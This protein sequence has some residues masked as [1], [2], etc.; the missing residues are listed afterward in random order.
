[1][2]ECVVGWLSERAYDCMC[3]ESLPVR[4]STVVVTDM[5]YACMRD[6]SYEYAWMCGVSRACMRGVS[7]ACVHV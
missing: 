2:S 4:M 7:Y 3:V 5:S 6:V 1:M